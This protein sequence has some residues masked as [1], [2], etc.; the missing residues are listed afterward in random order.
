VTGPTAAGRPRPRSR[1]WP[2]RTRRR[3]LIDILLIVGGLV[4][5]VFEPFSVGIHSIIGLIFAGTVGPHLWHRRS[6]IRGTLS[7]LLQRRRLSAKLRW[8][9]SQAFLLLVLVVAMTVSGL[10]DWLDVR[11]RIRWHAISSIIL[12]AVVARHAWTQRQ[13]LL[14][15]HRTG[16]P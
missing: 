3:W 1:L 13:W 8:S 10:Y 6:W 16:G 9:L 15:R 7:R 11:S 5:V 2:G 12:I 14:H 4:S